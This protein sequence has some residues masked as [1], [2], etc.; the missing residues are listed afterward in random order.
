[1]LLSGDDCFT[2]PRCG[3]GEM[4]LASS[5]DDLRSGSRFGIVVEAEGAADGG[6]R[7]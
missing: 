1:L 7:A 5:L 3:G 4:G 6:G 2:G